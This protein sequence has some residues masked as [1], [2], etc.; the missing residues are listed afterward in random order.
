MWRS[1]LEV[2]AACLLVAAL[3]VYLILSAPEES[4]PPPYPVAE[5]EDYSRTAD[6]KPICP[7]CGR[8]DDVVQYRY[9]LKADCPPGTVGAGCVVGPDSADFRCNHCRTN[10]GITAMARS[11]R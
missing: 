5:Y 8:S 9:G 3:P 7:R 1:L 10:F 4:R 6:G 11:A 2:A